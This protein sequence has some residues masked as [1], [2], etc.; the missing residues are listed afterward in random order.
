MGSQQDFRLTRGLTRQHLFARAKETFHLVFYGIRGAR[1][2][3][4]VEEALPM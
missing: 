1:I 3:V 4:D 2:E